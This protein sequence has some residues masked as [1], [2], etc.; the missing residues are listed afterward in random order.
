[1]EHEL[2]LRL[3]MLMG[4]DNM[5]DIQD[6]LDGTLCSLPSGHE[7]WA[8]PAC[9]DVS[10]DRAVSRN[11][12][13]AGPAEKSGPLL[14]ADEPANSYFLQPLKL[15]SIYIPLLFC[16]HQ[17]DAEIRVVGIFCACVVAVNV[18]SV[19]LLAVSAQQWEGTGNAKATNTTFVVLQ[20]ILLCGE[21]RLMRR[22]RYSLPWPNHAI[23]VNKCCKNYGFA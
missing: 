17:F 15:T 16:Q 23:D 19:G 4:N 22:R 9:W 3:T 21:S 6:C 13:R 1:M 8:R 12:K 18:F 20:I 2:R 5:H 7:F 10:V 11:A 14:F